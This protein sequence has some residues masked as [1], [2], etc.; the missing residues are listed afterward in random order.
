MVNPGI[1]AEVTRGEI[2]ESV[3]YGHLVILDPQGHLV[4]SI[5]DPH[6]RIYPRSTAKPLQAIAMIE[7]GLTLDD[8]HL[9]LVCASHSGQGEHREGVKE[10]L[11]T[12]GH[13][14]EDLHNT[15]GYPLNEK[16]R[17]IV[18]RQSPL[19]Q[20]CSGKH[21]GMIA[22]CEVAGWETHTYLDEHHPLQVK[23]REVLEEWT[24]DRPEHYVAD[25]CG[26]P[27]YTVSVTGLAQALN[28]LV[29]TENQVYRAM[30]SHPFMVGGSDRVVTQAMESVPGLLVKD[31]AE[32][33]CVAAH[34]DLGSIVFKAIDGS[35]RPFPAILAGALEYLGVPKSQL[36]WGYTPTLGHGREVGEVVACEPSSHE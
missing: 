34:P 33:V 22:T 18:D 29:T 13:T 19:F 6:A 36:T 21:A 10:I 4:A 24:G 25:G 31:G 30:T 17:Q 1:L 16:E 12:C 23:I 2:V 26:A 27:L 9:A 11:A 14:V 32:G 28:R 3:H 20:N 35:M 8:R 15:P 5:G 7:S